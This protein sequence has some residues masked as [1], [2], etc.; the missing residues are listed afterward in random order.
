MVGKILGSYRND[1]FKITRLGVLVN[2]MSFHKYM[3]L[4]HDNFREYDIFKF[5][6][7]RLCN[8]PAEELRRIRTDDLVDAY[9]TIIQR[10]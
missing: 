1:V 9:G 5:F 10:R 8:A 6:G 7:E 2:I 4:N 3:P